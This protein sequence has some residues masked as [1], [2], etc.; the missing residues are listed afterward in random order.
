MQRDFTYIDDLAKG[1]VLLSDAIP[2]SASDTET[3]DAAG[4]SPVAPFRIVNIGN[5]APVTLMAFV[6]A[7]ES[8][9][10]KQAIRNYLPMQQGDMARTYADSSLLEKLTGFRPATPVGIGVQ[11]F[12]RWYR[13]YYNI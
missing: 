4:A 3:D 7:I 9:I 13:E 6:E 12:V 1:V 2:L 11:N 10:G 8:A 5:G